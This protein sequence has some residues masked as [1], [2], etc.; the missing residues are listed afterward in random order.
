MR[1][2]PKTALLYISCKSPC[3]VRSDWVVIRQRPVICV[4]EG[5]VFIIPSRH[6]QLYVMAAAVPYLV[7]NLAVIRWWVPTH[8]GCAPLLGWG[9]LSNELD[10][11]ICHSGLSV[12]VSDVAL[13]ICVEGVCIA[14]EDNSISGGICKDPVCDC[15]DDCIMNV[16][17]QHMDTSSDGSVMI[18]R[19]LENSITLHQGAHA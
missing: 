16:D 5:P 1:S 3:E 14:E 2:T 18:E 19:Y 7:Y 10:P 11:C 9:T 12:K 15:G 4:A 6:I 13:Q 17:E 8:E